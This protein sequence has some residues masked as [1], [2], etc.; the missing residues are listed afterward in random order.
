[1]SILA[2]LEAPTA[3]RLLYRMK[4]VHPRSSLPVKRE[5]TM[6]GQN[7][8]MLTTSVFSNVAYGLKAR[9]FRKDELKP[10]V[11]EAL[12][13]VGL[14]GFGKRSA[15]KLSSGEAQRVAIA[16]ALAVSPCV[17]LLD[18][19]TSNVDP[20]NAE[21]IEGLIRNLREGDDVTVIM[22]TH[23]LS[24]AYRLADNVITLLDGR[25]SDTF[26]ENLFKA[27]IYKEGG[28]SLTR[29]GNNSISLV[30]DRAGEAYISIDPRDIIVSLEEIHSSARNSLQGTIIRIEDTG[31]AVMLGVEAGAEYNVQI[32]HAS[33][34]ELSLTLGTPVYL[35]FKS[36]AVSIF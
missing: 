25:V 31:K 12:H 20:M 16:R 11:E 26:K 10:R 27:Y 9:G 34:R 19:P 1:M 18:E 14:G 35:T 17:L 33:F 7:P 36:S 30:T 24:Q 32:T 4:E 13:K 29:V 2:L 3:G 22:S 6:V 8:V 5:I 15:R 23:N 21:I 28:E